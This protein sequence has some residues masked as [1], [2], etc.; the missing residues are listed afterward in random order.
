LFILNGVT[1]IPLSDIIRES[2]KFIAVLLAVLA[3]LVFN[4]D[5]VLFLPRALGYQG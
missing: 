3:F 5:F 1:N 4:P 2:W